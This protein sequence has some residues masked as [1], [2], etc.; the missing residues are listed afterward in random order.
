MLGKVRSREI[1]EIKGDYS[2]G[3]ANGGYSLSRG[4]DGHPLPFIIFKSR[5]LKC[6]VEGRLHGDLKKTV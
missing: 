2:I 6:F 1:T 3:R 5:R 4:Q